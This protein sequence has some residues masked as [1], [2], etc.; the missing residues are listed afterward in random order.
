[1][2]CKPVNG[3]CRKCNRGELL[4]LSPLV[5]GSDAMANTAIHTMPDCP[6]RLQAWAPIGYGGFF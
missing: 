5:K 2:N 1:M 3:T 4:K 6:I